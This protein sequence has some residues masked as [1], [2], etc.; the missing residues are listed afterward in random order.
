[1]CDNTTDV[2]AH[3]HQHRIYGSCP[4]AKCCPADR[5]RLCGDACIAADAHC[6]GQVHS[7][8]CNVTDTCCGEDMDSICCPSKGQ[9][10]VNGDGINHWCCKADQ[11]CHV[12]NENCI[13][14][15]G[16]QHSPINF[17]SS[18]KKRHHAHR[19]VGHP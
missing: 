15:D 8:Y 14:M 3:Q 13:A 17:R 19:G 11:R 9:C 6:C 4:R 10:C 5:P 7:K 2:C 16:S 12:L 18:G 1:M